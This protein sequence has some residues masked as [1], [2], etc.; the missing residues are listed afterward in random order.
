MNLFLNENECKADLLPFSATRHVSDIRIGILTI[1]EKWKLL[2]GENV[3]FLSTPTECNDVFSIP[4]NVIPTWDNYLSIIEFSKSS[5]QIPENDTNC[6]IHFPWEIFQLND[7]ALRKDFE[8]LTNNRSTAKIHSSNYVVN[9]KNIFIEEGA[10]VHNCSLNASLGPIYIG[11]NAVVMEGSMIRGPFSL[12]EKS[13]VKMGAKIYGATTIGPH[14]VVGGEIKNSVLF[15]YSN[16]AHDGYLG[17]SVVGA[18]CN[19]GAGTS[20]SN[21]KNTGEEVS[22][23]I[24]KD[25]KAVNIGNKG[26]LLMGDYSR[27]AINT[28]FNTGTVVGA[29]CNIFSQ[30]FSEKYVPHFSWGQEQYKLDKAFRDI[31]N[32]KKMKNETIT[33]QEKELLTKIY[34]TNK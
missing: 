10:E 34:S 9:E 25:K 1:R 28:S 30:G 8:L 18:W 23:Q 11:K 2:L 4:A 26:G 33:V 19:L 32:W 15:E 3:V 12:G 5:K 21:V 20:N 29:C 6:F 24:D 17:D 14:C 7:F 22:F 27:S 31:D 16:K 13:L